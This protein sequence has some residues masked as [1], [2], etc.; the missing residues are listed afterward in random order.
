MTD[1]GDV[2]LSL[3]DL[4]DA[5]VTGL[6]VLHAQRA[7]AETALGCAHAL[8][9]EAFRSPEIQLWTAWEGEVLV[10]VGAWKRLYA[11]QGELKSFY[12]VESARGRGIAGLILTRI[13]ER[14]RGEGIRRLSLETGSWPYFEPARRF[15]R[16]HGFEVGPPFGSY[17]ENPNSVFMTRLL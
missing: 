15:Y 14:A 8:D 13:I 12:T 2:V 1:T 10:G 5:R 9:P 17:E 6:L 7:R 4:E 3:G 16:R 11:T